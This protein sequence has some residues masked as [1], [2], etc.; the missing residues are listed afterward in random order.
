[1]HF[2]EEHQVW[3]PFKQQAHAWRLAQA[4]GRDIW[5]PFVFCFL[6]KKHYTVVLGSRSFVSSFPS[7]SLFFHRLHWWWGRLEPV[8][9]L[10][11]HLRER[12]P[13]AD[14]V[15]WVR[16]HRHRVP[17]LRQA[18]LPRCD[19]VHVKCR[20]RGWGEAVEAIFK[21]FYEMAGF[22]GY[23]W[24]GRFFASNNTLLDAV[25]CPLG[26]TRH[27]QAFFRSRQ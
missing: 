14:E 13:E 4:S 5:I 23:L 1:M 9:P 18:Q 3:K 2:P 22:Q 12:Q 11:R 8:V 25:Y 16:L 15:L 6:N 7:S 27:I 26:L 17:H 19:H 21:A 10:Q 20:H 24:N